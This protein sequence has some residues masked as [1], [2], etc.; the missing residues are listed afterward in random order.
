MSLY[1]KSHIQEWAKNVPWQ[2]MRQVEQD[3]IITHALVKLYSEPLIRKHLA[4]RGG[5]ALN[6]LFFKPA[7]RYSEDIDLVQIEHGPIGLILDCVRDKLDSWL[8][9]PKRIFADG[10]ITL[11]YKTQSSEGFPI[12]LKV[13]INSREHFSVFGLQEYPFSIGSSWSN[14]QVSISSYKLEE[15][16]GT[17]MRA[18]Y[19]RRKGRDL[20]D[21]YIALTTIPELKAADIVH[22][23][24]SYMD[25]GGHKVSRALFLENM[26]QKL[27]NRD[28]LGDMQ[29]LLPKRQGHFQPELA[30]EHVREN[31]L[32]HL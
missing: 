20:F 3:L 28:F 4:F 32:I 18:L 6:K 25:F 23:F 1:P 21:L 19:Q 9:E 27:K 17:K 12:R 26:A 8:G 5:T 10:C 2:E 30:F 15:L 11:T 7:T 31:L 16:L 14:E 24:S 22:A 29:P 13:E